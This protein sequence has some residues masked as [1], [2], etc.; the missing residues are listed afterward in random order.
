MMFSG[1]PSLAGGLGENLP[2]LVDD[3]RVE[4]VLAFRACGASA[5]TCI[6]ISFAASPPRGLVVPEIS[7]SAAFEPSWWA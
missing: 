2:L 4:I 6:A 5:T 3:G 1:L 7:T